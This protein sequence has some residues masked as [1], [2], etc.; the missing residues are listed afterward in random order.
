MK[1]VRVEVRVTGKVTGKARVRVWIREAVKASNS[2]YLGSCLR[3]G[4]G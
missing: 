4:L 2:T 3:E 1:E